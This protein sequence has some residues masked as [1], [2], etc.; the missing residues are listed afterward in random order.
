MSEIC[1]DG[2]LNPFRRVAYLARNTVA[3]LFARGPT[4]PLERFLATRPDD[5]PGV[6]SPSRVLTEAFLKV[7]L[8]GLFPTGSVKVLEIGCG[9]G[10]LCG[11]L[12]QIGYSGCYLGVDIGDRFD[13][14]PVAGFIK[15]F[16]QA[17][18]LVFDPETEHYDL[19][20]SVSALEHISDDRI[21]ID[22]IPRWLSGTGLELHFVPSGWGL[23]VYLWHGWRQYPLKAIGVRFGSGTT[24]V[25]MGGLTTTVLH[26]IWITLGE[27]LLP[28]A[29]RRRWPRLYERMLNRALKWDGFLPW[30]PTMYAV[31]R[32]GESA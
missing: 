9:S 32:R 27:M 21:L 14:T 17:D 30:C 7:R 12:A 23:L 13:P 29:A 20:I 19:V 22:R 6:A 3:N 31:I 8:P 28:L 16:R 24:A 15:Q 1:G 18:A 5:T 10:R 2:R 11:Q 4:V 25:A 26:V